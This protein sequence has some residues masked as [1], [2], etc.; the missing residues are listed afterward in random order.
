MNWVFLKT[1]TDDNS[2]AKRIDLNTT[3]REFITPSA[4]DR[5]GGTWA[6]EGQG[7]LH[8]FDPEAETLTTLRSLRPV[9]KPRSMLP[10]A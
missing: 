8:H 7:S 10:G 6:D 5:I 4:F 9:H 2:D 3:E 1:G